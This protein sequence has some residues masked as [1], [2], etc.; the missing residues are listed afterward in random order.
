MAR[1]RD[2]MNDPTCARARRDAHARGAS[3]QPEYDSSSWTKTTLSCDARRR[4]LARFVWPW[5][6]VNATSCAWTLAR[7]LGAVTTPDADLRAFDGAYSL[8]FSAMGFLL[9]FRLARA[10]VRWWDCR[11]AFGGMVAATRDF[12]DVFLIYGESIDAVGTDDGIAWACAFVAA[13]KAFL[14]GVSE[15]PREEL[16]G[17]LSD[18]DRVRMSRAT[19]PPLY[20]VSMCRRAVRRVFHGESDGVDA[21]V[22]A[23]RASIRFELN[24]QLEFLALQEGALERLRATKIPEIYVIHLRTFLML[25]LTSMPFIFGNRW[26]WGTIPAVAC[27]SFALLGIEGAATECEIP[28]NPT[29]ANH[30]RMDAYVAGCFGNVS[31]MLDWNEREGRCPV[32]ERCGDVIGFGEPGVK[33]DV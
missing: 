11:S 21:S 26:S 16:A 7:E 3:A 13:S 22:A 31:A 14:R 24:K 30:L 2:T 27:V 12:C 9:V 8:T 20:C 25:Y 33:V 6:F 23:S 29:H 4:G 17:I 28:F 32:G 1:L 15:T 18:E 5:A 19:H 10:A